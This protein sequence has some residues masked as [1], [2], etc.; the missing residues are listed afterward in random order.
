MLSVQFNYKQV[1]N[2]AFTSVGFVLF[3][4]PAANSQ[5]FPNGSTPKFFIC[6]QGMTRFA[7][8]VTTKHDLNLCGQE[9]KEATLLALRIRG[10]RQVVTVPILSSQDDVYFAQS[11]NG[12]AYKLDTN[13]KFLSIQPKKGKISREKVV[14]SD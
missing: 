8:L 2:L 1:L 14:A 3:L 10:K 5:P 6:P 13:K 12:T 4:I 7:T 9:G 11:A